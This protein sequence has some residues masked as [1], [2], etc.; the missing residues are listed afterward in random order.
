MFCSHDVTSTSAVIILYDFLCYTEAV[1]PESSRMKGTSQTKKAVG[2]AQEK[3]RFG[4]H[5]V[6]C[7]LS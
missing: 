5:V 2:K 4:G 6:K 7:N 1:I 3:L